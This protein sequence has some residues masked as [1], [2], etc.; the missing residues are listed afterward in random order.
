MKLEIEE[1]DAKSFDHIVYLEKKAKELDK[2]LDKSKTMIIRGAAGR[3]VPYG[4]VFV[5]DTLYFVE[6]DGSCEVGFCATVKSVYNS[7]ELD[8][9]DSSNLVI[10]NQKKLQLSAE[11]IKRWG[12]KRYLVLIEFEKFRKIDSFMFERESNMDDWIIVENIDN[13]KK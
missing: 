10:R 11:Q 5:G 7:E 9:D 2:I 1:I 4:R 12:G 6:N 8:T 13:I 3:K